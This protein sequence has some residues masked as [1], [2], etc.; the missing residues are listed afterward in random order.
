MKYGIIVIDPLSTL[1]DVAS[2]KFLIFSPNK[3]NVKCLLRVI[4]IIRCLNHL[5]IQVVLSSYVYYL[6]Q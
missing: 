5:F 1:Y 6:I 4:T 2:I 3:E